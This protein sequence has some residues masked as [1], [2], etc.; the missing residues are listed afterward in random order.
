MYSMFN[1]KECGAILF[2]KEI[3]SPPENLNQ[4]EKLIY[5]RVCDVQCHDCGKV[6]YSQPYDFGKKYN[7][8][9][10]LRKTD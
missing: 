3:E 4:A 9:K 1:C 8:V 6:Y 5:D 7:V 2:V 10:D